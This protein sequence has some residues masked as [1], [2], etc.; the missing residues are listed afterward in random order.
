[1]APT[2]LRFVCPPRG[3][4]SEDRSEVPRPR[5]DH[6]GT[7]T[8]ATFGNLDSMKQFLGSVVCAKLSYYI[9]LSF[10]NLIFNDFNLDF[11]YLGRSSLPV[12]SL[13]QPPG[14]D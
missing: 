4:L 2:H 14:R 10:R 5:G 9:V 13:E 8:A 6:G 12:L 3:C 11:D 1:M 7:G